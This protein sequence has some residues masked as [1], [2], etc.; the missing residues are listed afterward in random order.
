MTTVYLKDDIIYN[1]SDDDMNILKNESNLICDLFDLYYSDTPSTLNKN[2]IKLD[3]QKMEFK[4]ILDYFK[5]DNSFS[6]KLSLDKKIKVL[7]ASNY[8]MID[9]LIEYLTDEIV[10]IIRSSPDVDSLREIFMCYTENDKKWALR[11]PS[12]K[13]E[14]KWC[15]K[16]VLSTFDGKDIQFTPTGKILSKLYSETL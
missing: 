14:F 15:K 9:S 2:I 8:L 10:D 11:L 6:R 7:S 12:I 1:V 16:H 13:N 3:I 4:I 5:H